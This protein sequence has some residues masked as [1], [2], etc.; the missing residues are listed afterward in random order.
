[1]SLYAMNPRSPEVPPQGQL[2]VPTDLI[3]VSEAADA[4]GKS[5][6][7]IYLLLRNGRLRGFKAGRHTYVSKDELHEALKPRPLVY[8][9]YESKTRKS[10]KKKGFAPG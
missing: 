3:P 5:I 1:M 9:P 8:V 10:K 6:G 2:Q 7:S 4:I